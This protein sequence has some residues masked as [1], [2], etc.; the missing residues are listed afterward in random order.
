M[1][2]GCSASNRH[3]PLL[4]NGSLEHLHVGEEYTRLVLR[5]PR[6]GVMARGGMLVYLSAPALL[7]S[8]EAHPISVALRG[9]P[10]CLWN[11]NGGG[12]LKESNSH[13]EEV[14]TVCECTTMPFYGIHKHVLQ[15]QSSDLS[16]PG[17]EPFH[18]RNDRGNRVAKP[19]CIDAVFVSQEK[20]TRTSIHV[21]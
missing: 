16:Q 11:R 8:G 1:C 19:G 17:L 12:T 2:K 10:P 14:F 18:C 5:I 7:G 15:K 9:S 21:L 13:E 6:N 20:G 3:G 4:C